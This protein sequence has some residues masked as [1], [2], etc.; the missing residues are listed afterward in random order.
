MSQDRHRG[1]ALLELRSGIIPNQVM[2]GRGS[3]S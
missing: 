3:L 2:Y 1:A